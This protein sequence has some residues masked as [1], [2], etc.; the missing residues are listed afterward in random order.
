MSKVFKIVEA[1][2]KISNK[3]PVE[4]G[5]ENIPE[6]ISDCVEEIIEAVDADGDG[7]ITKEE[8]VANAMKSATIA[9][10]MNKDVKI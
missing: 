8:F 6:E 3:N 9:K 1:V 10:I 7:I 4:E 2:Y 5:Q